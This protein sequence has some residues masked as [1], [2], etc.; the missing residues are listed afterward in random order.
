MHLD[1]SYAVDGNETKKLFIFLSR[2]HYLI[3][4]NTDRHG[5]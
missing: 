2:W 1:I 3:V 4:N 5:L